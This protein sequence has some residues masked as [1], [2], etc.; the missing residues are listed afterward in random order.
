[1]ETVLEQ[2]HARWSR[3]YR[4]TV[5]TLS[6]LIPT[7]N[8]RCI[9]FEIFRI[10]IYKTGSPSLQSVRGIYSIWNIQRR[11]IR[12][13][14]HLHRLPTLGIRDTLDTHPRG[15]RSPRRGK[16]ARERVDRKDSRSI[17]WIRPRLVSRGVKK[18]RSTVSVFVGRKLTKSL[19]VGRRLSVCLPRQGRAS[20]AF[21]SRTLSTVTA[22]L[23]DRP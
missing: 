9:A 10:I 5:S 23:G 8:F 4:S 16:L 12:N 19:A 21:H 15:V 11:T 20:T 2:R 3:V 17:A 13:E 6:F 18:R 22:A 1:M 7:S 14:V